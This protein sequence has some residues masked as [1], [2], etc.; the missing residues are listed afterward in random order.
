MSRYNP[1]FAGDSEFSV[2][3]SKDLRI[4]DEVRLSRPLYSG[5]YPHGEFCG[6]ETVTARVEFM[7]EDGLIGFAVIKG[8]SVSPPKFRVKAATL[9]TRTKCYRRPRLN[10]AE[11]Q[12]EQETAKAKRDEEIE[13]MFRKW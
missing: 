5:K 4:E 7:S 12:A 3:C 6:Y 2:E 13:E 9:Q 8:S 1:P 10:E 11:I